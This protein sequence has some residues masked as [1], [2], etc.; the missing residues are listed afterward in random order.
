MDSSYLGRVPAL[1]T[2]EPIYDSAWDERCRLVTVP[3]GSVFLELF[4]MTRFMKKH[5]TDVK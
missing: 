3:A 4:V 5:N 1:L 2:H